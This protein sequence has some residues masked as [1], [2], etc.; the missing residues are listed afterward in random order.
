MMREHI[1]RP[2]SEGPPRK[3]ANRAVTG[4][5]VD[6]AHWRV[7]PAVCKVGALTDCAQLTTQAHT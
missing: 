1:R 4:L 5:T 3:L 7:S 6:L 2:R